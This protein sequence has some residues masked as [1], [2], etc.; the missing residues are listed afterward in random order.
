MI[1]KII[2]KLKSGSVEFD[3][4][5]ADLETSITFSKE[6]YHPIKKNEKNLRIAFID[7][8]NAELIKN[9]NLSLHFIRIYYAIFEGKKRIKTKKFEYYC[10]IKIKDSRFDVEFFLEDESEPILPKV[11]HLNL[12]SDDITIKQGLHRASVSRIGEI[13]RLFSECI[14][15]KDISTDVDY[16]LMDGTLQKQV[17]NHEKYLDLSAN[18]CALSKSSELV[19][20]NGQSQMILIM[21][22]H[23]QKDLGISHD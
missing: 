19:T 12:N 5:K 22:I 15:A 18:V 9:A 7:G 11:E 20:K 14:V 10:L 13:A 3:S 16:V 17:T 23:L 4:D 8:G 2:S 21:H 6:N 1:N